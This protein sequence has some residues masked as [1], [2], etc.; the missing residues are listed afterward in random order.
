METRSKD[1]QVRTSGLMI[2]RLFAGLPGDAGQAGREGRPGMINRVTSHINPLFI[3]PQ[4][5][6]GR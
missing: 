1:R 6:P 3:G 2:N 5:P 4:G